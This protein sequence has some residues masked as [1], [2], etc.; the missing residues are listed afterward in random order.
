MKHNQSKTS[1]QRARR[2]IP[3]AILA[4]M[5]AMMGCEWDNPLYDEF[6]NEK[7]DNGNQLAK[8]EDVTRIV[9]NTK[10]GTVQIINKGDDS[11]YDV[12][13][14]A[15]ICPNDART[16]SKDKTE[17]NDCEKAG[18]SYCG[19]CIDLSNEA[20]HVEKC[21]NNS[22]KCQE[23]SSGTLLWDNCDG[24]I[25]NGCEADLMNDRYHC[26]DCETKCDT[27]TLTKNSSNR[28]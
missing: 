17:C 5:T 1:P 12:V 28:R 20:W 10:E 14:E 24:A 6:V 9:K 21:E 4:A 23:S 25:A 18:E 22:I 8:C 7:D 2:L 13:F 26:G 27:G 15:K 3:L 16:C 19:G 11:D